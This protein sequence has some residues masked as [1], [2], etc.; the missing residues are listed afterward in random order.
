MVA[1]WSRRGALVV[2]TCVPPSTVVHASQHEQRL[3]RACDTLPVAQDGLGVGERDDRQVLHR[4]A[5][6]AAA[7]DRPGNQRCHTIGADEH[8][9]GAL[10]VWLERSPEH[11][12]GP[13]ARRLPTGFGGVA[14]ER[15]EQF[16]DDLRQHRQLAQVHQSGQIVIGTGDAGQHTGNRGGAQ[17]HQLTLVKARQLERA[18]DHQ[19]YQ[20]LIVS[21]PRPQLGPGGVRPPA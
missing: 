5:A 10:K 16:P 12:L 13:V 3:Q 15:V 17:F 18:T 21:Q 1:G 19:V 7:Q 6:V 11:L 8:R 14:K 2:R 4:E 20:R 9:T